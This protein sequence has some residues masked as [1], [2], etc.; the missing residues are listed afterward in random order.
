MDCA[1]QLSAEC[2]RWALH[3]GKRSG[4]SALMCV[5]KTYFTLSQNGWLVGWF[6]AYTVGWFGFKVLMLYPEDRCLHNTVIFYYLFCME[7]NI[8]CVVNYRSNLACIKIIGDFQPRHC[9]ACVS[10]F[11]FVVLN[12][13]NAYWIRDEW[14]SF[15]RQ[16][17][18]N[19]YDDEHWASKL[20]YWADFPVARNTKAGLN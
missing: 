5:S 11:G 9:W 20:L 1:K 10:W 18:N 13:F 2:P 17:L 12:C 16:P 3:A 19:K 7:M 14:T 6:V 15:V 4:I 8:G